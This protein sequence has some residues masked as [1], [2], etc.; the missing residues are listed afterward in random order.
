MSGSACYGGKL[1]IYDNPNFIPMPSWVSCAP[2]SMEI[3][4][5]AVQCQPL[6]GPPITTFLPQPVNPT[7]SY[8]FYNDTN[9][10]RP[11]FGCTSC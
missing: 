8:Y 5:P 11:V 10:S 4:A 6:C 3:I 9:G 2:P 1:N 7:L